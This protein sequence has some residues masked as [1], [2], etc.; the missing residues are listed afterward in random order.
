MKMIIEGD[1]RKGDIVENQ[2]GKRGTVVKLTEDEI[3]ISVKGFYQSSSGDIWRK[4]PV[5]DPKEG[6]GKGGWEVENGN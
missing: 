6:S 4:I 3:E 2:Q 5:S 1:V